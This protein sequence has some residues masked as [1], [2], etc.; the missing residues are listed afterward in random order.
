M[1]SSDRESERDDDDDNDYD[2]INDD[3]VLHQHKDLSAKQLFLSNV[4]VCVF[5]C[6]C[7]SACVYV[8]V[9]VCVVLRK[10]ISRFPLP[11]SQCFFS[12]GWRIGLTSFACC[13]V[14]YLTFLY[15][16]VYLT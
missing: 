4:R 13:Q 9:C 2:D 6:V 7:V 3:T 8:Y 11:R 5:V 15:I 1:P 12:Y 14:V 10:Q 16:A